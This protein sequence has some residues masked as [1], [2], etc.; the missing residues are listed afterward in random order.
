MGLVL[1]AGVKPTWV[2]NPK[3]TIEFTEDGTAVCKS[4][5][6]AKPMRLA[7]CHFTDDGS[8]VMV[9]HPFE[10]SKSQ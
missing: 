6:F 7:V 10:P 1:P 3:L 8:I 2:A 9:V 4:D 5:N